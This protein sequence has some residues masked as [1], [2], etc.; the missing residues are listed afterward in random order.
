MQLSAHL[1]SCCVFQTPRTPFSTQ[2]VTYWIRELACNTRSS[3]TSPMLEKRG[4]QMEWC[5]LE[6]LRLLQSGA[7]TL[8]ELRLQ[9][10]SLS[11]ATAWCLP[12]QCHQLSRRLQSMMPSV[13]DAFHRKFHSED[14]AMR[15]SD[16][17]RA[18]SA[19]SRPVPGLNL[20]TSC[21]VSFTEQIAAVHDAFDRNL[22]TEGS[23]MWRSH[24][25]RASS[26]VGSFLLGHS[27]VPP[28][29]VLSSEGYIP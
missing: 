25:W 24:S 3:K 20:T 9:W 15:R 13:R 21:T 4:L 11:L 17:W 22:R 27:L 26:A 29:A 23:A 12:A 28:N 6:H 7:P 10:A 14:T 5:L 2:G 19:V 18:S 16:S 8:G 1:A